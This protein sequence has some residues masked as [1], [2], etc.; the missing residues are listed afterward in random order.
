MKIGQCSEEF[1][2]E[3]KPVNADDKFA[4]MGSDFFDAVD[5]LWRNSIES[6][7]RI[8]KERARMGGL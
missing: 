5:L 2:D 8:F 3:V 6:V 7:Q 4:I 1:L